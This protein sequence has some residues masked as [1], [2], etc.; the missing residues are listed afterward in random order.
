MMQVSIGA[1]GELSSEF[2]APAVLFRRS[3]RDHEFREAFTKS[4]N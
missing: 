2:D 4:S 3:A 1:A